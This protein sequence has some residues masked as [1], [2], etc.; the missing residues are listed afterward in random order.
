MTVTS[1]P[2]GSLLFVAGA[3]TAL[4]T[5]IHNV[6]AMVMAMVAAAIIDTPVNYTCG[7]LFGEKLLSYSNLKIFRRS[8][9]DSMHQ[10]YKKYAR[11]II[12]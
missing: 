11:K 10:F 5:N 3:P 1:L 4:Q 6:Y 7:R 2:G 8:Y 9:L 12:L